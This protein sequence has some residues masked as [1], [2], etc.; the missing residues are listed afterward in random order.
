MITNF[1]QQGESTKEFSK[2]LFICEN[3]LF[4]IAYDCYMLEF[5]VACGAGIVKNTLFQKFDGFY[6]QQE[7]RG[8]RRGL[9]SPGE[10]CGCHSDWIRI[11]LL[12]SRSKMGYRLV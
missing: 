7:H 1:R 11:R 12:S 6:L 3:V 8:H 9:E 4:A 10:Y 5:Y 2:K